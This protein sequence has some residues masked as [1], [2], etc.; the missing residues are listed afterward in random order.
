MA[1]IMKRNDENAA[2]LPDDADAGDDADAASD[3]VV[4]EKPGRSAAKPGRAGKGDRSAAKPVEY[5]KPTTAS[6]RTGKFFTIYKSG[7]GYWTRMGTLIGVALLGLMLAYT[8]YD[9]I[10]PFIPEPDTTAL[11]RSIDQSKAPG[12]E[13]LSDAQIAAVTAQIGAMHDARAL[14]AKRIA[15][16]V[17]GGF[18]LIYTI[19]ALYMMNKPANVDFLIA[20][21]SEMKKVN[22]TS[23]KEL[24]GSTKIVVIFM[25]L[26]AF[27]L[28]S[29]DWI[30]HLIFYLVH[31]LKVPPPGIPGGQ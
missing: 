17:S 18:L 3:E 20:T 25:L 28:F 12:A 11:Q 2:G 21:D 1:S 13:K 31:V 8:L 5:A 29:V 6:G 22:W 7:Q 15:I 23:R 9:K 4:D 26:I 16:G 27:F 19:V 14:L 30:F 24:I 10:P